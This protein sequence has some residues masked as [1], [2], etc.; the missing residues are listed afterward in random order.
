M[1]A[2]RFTSDCV[3]I[4]T[5]YLVSGTGPGFVHYGLCS[6]NVYI[7]CSRLIVLYSWY[8]INRGAN[9]PIAFI[10]VV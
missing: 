7:I 4:V 6:Y 1:R 5:L 2:Y 3:D 10:N 8:R 9:M